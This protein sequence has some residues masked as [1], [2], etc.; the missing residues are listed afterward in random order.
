ML[1][2]CPKLFRQTEPPLLL[3]AGL[4]RKSRHNYDEDAQDYSHYKLQLLPCVAS[5]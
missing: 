2:K 1:G 3:C 5:H 4:D